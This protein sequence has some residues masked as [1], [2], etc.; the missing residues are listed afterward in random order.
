VLVAA[1][2]LVFIPPVGAFVSAPEG[3]IEFCDELFCAGVFPDPVESELC[4]QPTA[5]AVNKPKHTAKLMILVL[6]FIMI[7]SLLVISR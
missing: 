7:F 6:F 5:A 3:A 1:G 2:V 4:W